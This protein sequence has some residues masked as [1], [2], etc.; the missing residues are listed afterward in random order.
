[1][2]WSFDHAHN[3]AKS[4]RRTQNFSIYGVQGENTIARRQ[5]AKLISIDLEIFNSFPKFS[6]IKGIKK[7]TC[8]FHLN[9]LE[10]TI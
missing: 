4:Y 6:E 8:E 7:I 9:L 5:K 1:M 10:N 3:K 2:R